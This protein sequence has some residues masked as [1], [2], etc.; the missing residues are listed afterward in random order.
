MTHGSFGGLMPNKR[1]VGMSDESAVLDDFGKR[2]PFARLSDF[3]SL[4]VYT[5]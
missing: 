1:A 5:V 3:D 4:S 2:A